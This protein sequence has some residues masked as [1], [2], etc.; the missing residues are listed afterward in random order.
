M[1]SKLFN[2]GRDC[3][4]VLVYN[5]SRIDL[6]TV[7]GF[8]SQQQ[9]TQLT[10]KPLNDE[11]VFYDVPNGWRGTFTVQR[12]G[13][14]LDD[15]MI[16]VEAGFWSAGT[17]LLGT[18]YQYVTEVDGTQSTYEYVG[19]SLRQPEAGNFQSENIVSQRLEFTARRRNKI[20]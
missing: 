7:T 15:L 8:Q 13:S 5:G 12:D 14:A 16:A 6:P 18:I 4:V 9:T 17:M 10:S 11:P 20:S 1:A 19:A 3:R 2:V